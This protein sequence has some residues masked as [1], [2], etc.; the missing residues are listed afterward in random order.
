M[1]CGRSCTSWR[2]EKGYCTWIANKMSY[3]S[4]TATMGWTSRLSARHFFLYSCIIHNM[5][6]SDETP[7][8]DS[9]SNS[10]PHSH[11]TILRWDLKLWCPGDEKSLGS[12]TQA[13][14]HTTP[15]TASHD[16]WLMMTMTCLSRKDALGQRI[17]CWFAACHL[18]STTCSLLPGFAF[19]AVHWLA[20]TVQLGPRW[21]DTCGGFLRREESGHEA[22]CSCWCSHGF[23]S[24]LAP[25]HH[26]GVRMEGAMQK[27]CAVNSW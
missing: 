17:S 5:C 21:L 19:R 15:S 6:Q 4:V 3:I 22:G 27:L 26:S 20:G 13:L 16:I 9:W 24:S 2:Q 10:F 23:M 7:T 11:S 18:V 12:P 14:K 1:V 25:T 8:Y